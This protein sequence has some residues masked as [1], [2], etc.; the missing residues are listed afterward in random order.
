MG[1]LE[2]MDR[3]TVSLW[4]VKPYEYDRYRTI[5]TR[6]DTFKDIPDMNLACRTTLNDPT[7]TNLAQ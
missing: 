7:L 5:V 4:G 2:V 1:L 6:F 3:Y